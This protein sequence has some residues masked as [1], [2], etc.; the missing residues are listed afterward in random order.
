[1]FDLGVFD[2]I[3]VVMLVASIIIRAP[4]DKEN[5][6][7]KTTESRF[8]S[9]E[10]AALLFAVSGAILIPL[11]YLV[12]PVLNFANY[13]VNPWQ[14]IAG[15]ILIIPSM[16]L[17]WRSH[18]DLGRQFS[19]KLEIKESHQLIT[20]GVYKYVRHPMYTAVLFISL[21]QLLLIGN[22]IAGPAYFIGFTFL[23][24]VR[25]KR[26]EELMLQQFGEGYAIYMKKT[27]R[28]FPG[29]FK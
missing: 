25:V 9:L 18:K 29:I 2:V 6:K 10:R 4:Y 24:L 15:T 7:S 26:E 20:S 19:P 22:W 12:T 28:L 14:C 8:D 16:W 11:L 23:Y 3:F 1:M 17:F 5:R 21:S 27:N 13:T